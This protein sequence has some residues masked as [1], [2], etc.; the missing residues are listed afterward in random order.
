MKERR[1]YDLS[2]PVFDHCPGWPTYEPAAVCYEAVHERDKFAAEQIRMNSH[3][4]T[5]I[6]APYHFFAD[7]KTIDQIP[8][9]YFQGHAVILDLENAVRAREGIS[10]AL[11]E[12][13]GKAVKEND[14]VLLRTGWGAKRSFDKEYTKDW[15]Y[16]SG[17]GAMWLAK[18]GVKGVGIDCM[19]M[20]GWYEG[21]GRPCHEILLSRGI[22]L[23]EELNIPEELARYENCYLISF[24]LK[25]QGFSGAPA[26]VA[27]VV[28]ETGQGGSPLP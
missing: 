17:D 12:K 18:K 24:P 14:I 22:W 6:D 25:L 3:T 28:D 9:E 19:S 23:L 26:R 11:L 15:P 1:F 5:H 20:G 8:L 7:G 13:Q 10:A 21:T 27:A 4:G 16:L 2:Q